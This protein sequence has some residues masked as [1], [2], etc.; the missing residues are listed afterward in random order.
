MRVKKDENGNMDSIQQIAASNNENADDSPPDVI[1][2][3][4]DRDREHRE[5]LPTDTSDGD[6]TNDN[7]QETHKDRSQRRFIDKLKF[8]DYYIRRF[9]DGK[10]KVLEAISTFIAVLALPNNYAYFEARFIF[11]R[12]VTITALVF[13]LI[14]LI[15]HLSTLW[16]RLPKHMTASNVLMLFNIL[17]AMSFAGCCSLVI[18]VAEFSGAT[19]S[20]TLIACIAGFAAM[21]FFGLESFL[22]LIRYRTAVPGAAYRKD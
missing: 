14:D 3:N 17:A 7:I 22:H 1:V 2:V 16:E 20:D 19:L 21:L 9:W 11:F 18:G 12:F 8:D 4:P 5:R 6:T 10:L 15:L 13:V